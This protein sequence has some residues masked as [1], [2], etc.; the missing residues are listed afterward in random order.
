MKKMEILD[1]FCKTALRAKQ[2]FK[3]SFFCNIGIIFR[4]AFACF[5]GDLILAG[6]RALSDM[7]RYRGRARRGAGVAHQEPSIYNKASNV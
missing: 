1:E 6:L 4:L 5:L 3:I 7:P 2:A